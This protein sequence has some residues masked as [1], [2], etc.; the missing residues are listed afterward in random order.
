MFE[1]SNYLNINNA[2]WDPTENNL[3]SMSQ[4]GFLQRSVD[5]LRSGSEESGQMRSDVHQSAA[6]TT[7]VMHERKMQ[8]IILQ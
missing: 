3:R 7:I 4:Q 6:F 1:M 8:F 2:S 5:V